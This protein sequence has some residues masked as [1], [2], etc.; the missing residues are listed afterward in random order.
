MKILKKVKNKKMVK[1]NK[2]KFEK[3]KT[4]YNL[5]EKCSI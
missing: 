2:Y 1:D 5:F 4:L 3:S